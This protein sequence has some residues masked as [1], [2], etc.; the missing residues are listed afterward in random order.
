MSPSVLPATKSS[1]QSLPRR[2]WEVARTGDFVALFW[3][4]VRFG[5]VGL[6]TLGV[7]AVEMWLLARLTSWPTWINATISYV[8]CLVL[9]YLLHRTFTFRSTREHGQ[10]G[11]RYLVIQLGG[12]VINT[13]VLWLG[14]ERL[15]WPYLP[16]QVASVLMLAT[17]SYLG[18]KLWTFSS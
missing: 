9:N 7:Y 2:L 17:W 1:Q 18:Q 5:W 10:A 12:L 6:F 15:G 13:S 8:P 11:P 4:F 3:E 14:V 16:S